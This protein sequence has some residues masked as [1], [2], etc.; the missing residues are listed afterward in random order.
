MIAAGEHARLRFACGDVF[1]GAV[2]HELLDVADRADDDIVALQQVL[3]MILPAQASSDDAELQLVA[4]AAGF[5][6]TAERQGQC[7]GCRCGGDEFAT[8]HGCD[9]CEGV[10]EICFLVLPTDRR[11]ARAAAAR[12]RRCAWPDLH[13]GRAASAPA[14]ASHRSRRRA[15]GP[16]VSDQAIAGAHGAGDVHRHVR[17]QQPAAMCGHDAV[18]AERTTG[19]GTPR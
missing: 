8:L 9:S 7:G 12:H 3:Q 15:S 2:E 13:I 16:A 5:A 6:E 4:G 18:R 14:G 1:Q 11:H 10:E 19:I 17:V